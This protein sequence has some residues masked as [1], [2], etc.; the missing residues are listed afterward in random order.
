L[1]AQINIAYLYQSAKSK[2][3]LFRF[4]ITQADCLKE[5]H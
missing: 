1:E 2:V 5:V 3:K 4:D